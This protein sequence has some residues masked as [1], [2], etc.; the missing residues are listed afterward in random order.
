[1][2]QV[3]L[4]ADVQCGLLLWPFQLFRLFNFE[5]FDLSKFN[6]KSLHFSTF[7][8]SKMSPFHFSTSRLFEIQNVTF[9]LLD[10]SKLKMTPS[11][12]STFRFSKSKWNPHTFRL[13]VF[14]LFEIDFA[15]FPIGTMQ[16]IFPTQVNPYKVGCCSYFLASHASKGLAPDCAGYFLPSV[17]TFSVS[18]SCPYEETA[19]IW[20]GVLLFPVHSWRNP[21]GSNEK[22]NWVKSHTYS[23]CVV[24]LFPRPPSCPCKMTGFLLSTYKMCWCCGYLSFSQRC[25]L[26]LQSVQNCL[27]SWHSSCGSFQ[28]KH[29]ENNMIQ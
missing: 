13:F 12:F 26:R 21:K 1:M 14:W 17:Y 24:F 20:F 3:V 25:N 18:P 15:Y 27:G 5:L 28:K 9:P 23:I 8:N 4:D 7:R 2:T 11:H 6:L 22:K 29:T 19:I 10:F 16:R